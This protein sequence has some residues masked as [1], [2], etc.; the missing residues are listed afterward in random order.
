[1]TAPGAVELAPELEMVVDLAVVA[2]PPTAVPALHRLRAG[3]RQIEDREPRVAEPGVGRADAQCLRRR[4]VRAAV[5]ERAERG[6][7]AQGE[8]SV[9]DEAGYAAHDCVLRSRRAMLRL[10]AERRISSRRRDTRSRPCFSSAVR[11]PA[12]ESL[13]HSSASLLSRRTA[14][15]KSAGDAARSAFDPGSRS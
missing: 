4:R 15:T 1:M 5:R 9:R 6:L 13:R 14:P 10:N 12:L 2:H 11:T 7:R 3:R 8:G